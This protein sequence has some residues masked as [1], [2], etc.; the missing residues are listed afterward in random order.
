MILNKQSL[1]AFLLFTS[2]FAFC[3][4]CSADEWSDA[5]GQFQWDG[6]LFA[7]D[8][9]MAVIRDK[10]GKLH[11]VLTKELSQPGQNAVQEFLKTAASEKDDDIQTWVL[12]SG[13][14]VR[15]NVLGYKSGVVI[16]EDRSGSAYVNKKALN[17]IDPVYQAMLPRLIERYEDKNVT[18]MDTFKRWVRKLRG[19]QKEL[20]VDGVLMKLESGDEYAVPIF[21]FSKQD[22][23]VLSAGWKQWFEKETTDKKRQQEDLMIRAEAADYQQKT[24]QGNQE[25]RQIEMMKLNLL[26]VDAGLTSLWEVQMATGNGNYGRPLR[27]VVP[28][29]NSAEARSTALQNN[30]GYRVTGLRQVS[31]R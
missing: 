27:I 17:K 11:A 21:M 28:A 16:I 25:R 1:A 31:R 10:K 24:D 12:N 7:A 6:D 30:P 26:A 8:A 9:E 20:T 13:L 3:G 29:R 5:S 14:K 15:A 19:G 23:E 4:T 2:A 18:S 22:A